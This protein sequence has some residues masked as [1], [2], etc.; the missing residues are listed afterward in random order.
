[1]SETRPFDSKLAL[2]KTTAWVLKKLFGPPAAPTRRP[3]PRLL[4][5]PIPAPAAIPIPNGITRARVISDGRGQADADAIRIIQGMFPEEM[6]RLR[7]VH[8]DGAPPA[9]DRF[10]HKLSNVPQGAKLKAW[11]KVQEVERRHA[12]AVWAMWRTEPETGEHHVLAEDAVG[13]FFYAFEAAI[14]ILKDETEPVLGRGRFDGWIAA[15]PNNTLTFRSIRT[16]RHL[17]VHVED[18]R[19]GGGLSISVV[20]GHGGT[21]TRF[22][23]A[24]NLT[25]ELLASLRSSK[26]RPDELDAYKELRKQRSVGSLMEQALKDLRQ[27]ISDAEQLA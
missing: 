19:S 22:W 7:V 1:M 25:A 27:I 13:A 10:E 2:M 17:A 16:I 9:L 18:I 12:V 23:H 3:D 15:H 11:A 8:Q 24:P 20:K 26:I 14:Q 21:V 4:A 6:G 5:I